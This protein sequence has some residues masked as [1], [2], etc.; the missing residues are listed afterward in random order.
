MDMATPPDELLTRVG[1]DPG[2]YTTRE[3]REQAFAEL[4]HT[5]YN[6]IGA[7]APPSPATVLDFGCGS[8]R[9]LQWWLQERPA[10]TIT[11]CDIHTPSI[12]WLRAN[13]PDRVR[14][15]VNDETPPLPEADDTFD[16]VYCGSVFSHL[17]DWA[18]WLLELLRVLKPG[19][20]LV[21]SFHG[22]GFW[23]LGVHGSRGV[24]WD[25][26][27]IGIVVERAG[28]SF[29]SSWG[30]AVY[31]SEW[32]M[33]CHWGAA[34]EIVEYHPTGFGFPHDRGNGQGWVVG[35]KRPGALP[36][37]AAISA[38]SD[39]PREAAAARHALELA[40]D[41][42]ATVHIPE[43]RRLWAALQESSKAWDE[44][45]VARAELERIRA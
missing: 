13:H 12:D 26:D 16:L 35:R 22:A 30:P 31:V 33:R 20:T 38:P 28:E 43:V 3:L 42:I 25:E 34:M 21:A 45:A 40:Y 8:G 41:E 19:G 32:W 27:V 11:G 39:D 36:T 10:D 18:P 29:D 23:P 24:P 44:L 9:I 37:A 7:D 6:D 5:A 4:G 17:T 15:Y 2:S 1:I 14:L